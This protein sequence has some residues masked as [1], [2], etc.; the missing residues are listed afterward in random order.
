MNSARTIDPTQAAFWDSL[1]AWP[2]DTS[3]VEPYGVEY[4]TEPTRLRE[5]R[6]RYPCPTVID[7]GHGVFGSVVALFFVDDETGL[8]IAYAPP[9]T[10]L[11]TALQDRIETICVL[12]DGLAMID[13]LASDQW[14]DATATVQR[15]HEV[16][17]ETLRRWRLVGLDG[18][19]K[20][21]PH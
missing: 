2:L 21:A 7:V 4:L 11:R 8:A 15:M 13:A 19:S 17:V 12:R 1:G 3:D 9:H 16:A 14:Q 10:V 20:P 5:V 18:S 6:R